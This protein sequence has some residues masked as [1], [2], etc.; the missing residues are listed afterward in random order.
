MEMGMED[1]GV[2]IAEQGRKRGARPIRRVIHAGREA[3]IRQ[4]LPACLP[5]PTNSPHYSSSVQK[6]AYVCV[7]VLHFLLF[8]CTNFCIF[9]ISL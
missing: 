3:G 9:F 5:A 1:M 4:A 7:C 2:Y 8:L 6:S